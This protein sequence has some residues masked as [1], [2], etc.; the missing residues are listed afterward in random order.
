MIFILILSAV[1]AVLAVNLWRARQRLPKG[2]TPLPLIGNLHQ[3]VYTCWKAGG[4]VDG[5]H[6]FRK[7]LE[8]CS[9]SG[10]VLFLQYT[11]LTLT[12]HMRPMSKEPTLL[13]YGIRMEE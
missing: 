8:K 12:W 13:E 3:L 5:F 4:T 11:L 1:F 9:Q 10:W 6:E 2:P 7:E